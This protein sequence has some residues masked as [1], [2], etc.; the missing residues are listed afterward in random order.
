MSGTTTVQ[1]Q[2]FNPKAKQEKLCNMQKLSAETN[3]G[4]Q[5]DWNIHSVHECIPKKKDLWFIQQ[6]QRKDW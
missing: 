4:L 5:Q 3:N 1:I 6:K 2:R